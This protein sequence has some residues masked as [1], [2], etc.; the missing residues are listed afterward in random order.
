MEV[1]FV[2]KED[3]ERVEVLLKEILSYVGKGTITINEYSKKI[4]MSRESLYTERYRHYLPNYGLS[5][6]PE[7]YTRWKRETID[8]WESIPIEERRLAWTQMGKREREK[9][10]IRKRKKIRRAS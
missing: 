6:F 7:G 2:T 8:A 1:N 4:G 10:I 3:I 9:V 5:D